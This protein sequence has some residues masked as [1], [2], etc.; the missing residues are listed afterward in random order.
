MA[1][2]FKDECPNIDLD[3]SISLA[4]KS[5]AISGVTRNFEDSSSDGGSGKATATKEGERVNTFRAKGVCMAVCISQDR[6]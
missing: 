3:V 5:Y 6:C 2:S 1:C 4:P